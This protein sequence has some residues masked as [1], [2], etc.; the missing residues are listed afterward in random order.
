MASIFS[1]IIRGEL[2]GRFVWKDDRCV[3]LMTINPLTPGHT[4]VIP[5]AEVD[6]WIDLEPD[7]ARHLFSVAQSIGKAIQRAFTPVKV[8]LLIAGLEVRHAHLHLVPIRELHDLDFDRQE[9]N[10]DPAA[11]DRAAATLRTALRELGYREA[12]D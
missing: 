8:G 1:R 7:L 6:H 4:L 12:S 10:P 11:L 2:S 3:G 5:R 9:K